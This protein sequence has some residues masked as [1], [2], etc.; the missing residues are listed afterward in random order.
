M[1]LTVRRFQALP[2]VLTVKWQDFRFRFGRPAVAWLLVL[3]FSLQLAFGQRTAAAASLMKAS[4][5]SD[6]RRFSG[7][8]RRH[9]E[10]LRT[11]SPNLLPK[12]ARPGNLDSRCL[13]LAD[14]VIEQHEVRR[15]GVLLVSFTETAAALYSGF[16]PTAISE[17]F[18]VVLEPSWSGYADPAILCWLNL[19]DPVIVQTT[20]RSDRELLSTLAANLVPVEFGAGDWID[21]DRFTTVKE[22]PPKKYNAVSVAN[23]GSWKRNHAFIEGVAVARRKRPGYRAAL[24]LAG[25]G[26]SPKALKQL[27]DIMMF[28]G[29]QD[30]LD[31]LEGLG[32]KD[33]RIL[34]SQA[35]ALVFTSWKEGS[36]RVIF[37][38][39][40]ADCPAIVLRR[41]VGVNKDYINEHTG[42]LVNDRELGNA[43]VEF[44]RRTQHQSPRAW[45][46]ANLGP[47]N[48]TSKLA[49]Q[50]RLLYPQEGWTTGELATK[51]NIPEARHRNHAG[52]LRPLSA[53]LSG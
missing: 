45:F 34:F 29:V 27:Q 50:L 3:L 12:S 8:L 19:R 7:L 6:S 15:K 51:A 30:D 38:A 36:S 40:C 24:V 20:E 41:N 53:W 33:L 4:R 25:L 2:A 44:D 32:Q 23:F 49:Q 1:T 28:H 35:D 52:R 9:C 21:P 37:E 46:L 22:P 26:K 10:L 13:V 48:T 11:E 42:K 47:D 39:M 43:M 17:K 31:V 5:F 18:H 14:P 16:G